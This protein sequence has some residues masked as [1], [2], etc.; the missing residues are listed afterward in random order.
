MADQDDTNVADQDATDVDAT[1][2]QAETETSKDDTT[3]E[4]TDGSEQTDDEDADASEQQFEKRYTQ[5][6]GDTP[7]EYAKNLEHAYDNSSKE[8]L[9]LKK[10]L[11]ELR[12]EKLSDVANADD[13]G[14]QG[15]DQAA[16]KPESVTDI[17]VSQ[18][19]RERD[20]EHYNKF[21]AQHPEVNEDD[22]LFQ[23]LDAETGK[24][25]DYVFKTEK[26]VP[27]LDEALDFAWMRINPDDRRSKDEQVA[28][29]A[30]NAGAASRTKGAAKDQSKAQFSDKQIAA[31]QKID[32]K[33]RGKSRTEIE[34]ILS[35]YT[36]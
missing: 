4:S 30:K 32:P 31:A 33:L 12:A 9:R 16:D 13:S 20:V 22:E 27:G 28:A 18:M 21:A 7:E 10:Q 26:R 8:A 11:D 6:K 15:T 36:K 19:K 34:E 14:G 29:A 3:N 35:K 25:M 1:D 23:K 24:Y 17:L 2:S 5:F